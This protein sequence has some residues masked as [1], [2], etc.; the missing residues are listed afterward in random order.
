MTLNQL[1]NQI[2]QIVADDPQAGHLPV[3]ETYSV[4]RG[5]HS[6]RYNAYREIRRVL[7]GEAEVFVKQRSGVY[8][9]E[10]KPAV[11]FKLNDG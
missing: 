10:M 11:I 7:V 4:S 2:S 6:A 3:Y 9:P 5:H 8:H 1:V